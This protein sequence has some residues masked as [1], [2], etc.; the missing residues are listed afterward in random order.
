MMQVSREPARPTRQ[1]F[2]EQ[3]CSYCRSLREQRKFPGLFEKWPAT[4]PYSEV[5]TS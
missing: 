5:I 3:S 2:S 4:K 1:V